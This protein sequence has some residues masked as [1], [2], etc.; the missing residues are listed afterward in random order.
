MYFQVEGRQNKVL[1]TS[2]ESLVSDEYSPSRSNNFKSAIVNAKKENFEF[3]NEKNTS[4]NFGGF[5]LLK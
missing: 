3:F 5:H 4:F 1:G 2:Y